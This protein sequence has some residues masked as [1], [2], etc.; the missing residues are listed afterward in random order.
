MHEVLEGVLPGAVPAVLSGPSFAADV[1]QGLPTAVTLAT[2]DQARGARLAALFA[3]ASFRPYLS[4]DIIGVELGGAVK[5]VL[6]IAAGIVAGRSLGES[7]RAALIARGLAEMTRF[8]MA[9]GAARE[10]FSGLSGLG[11]LVLTALS[12]RSRNMALGMALGQGRA[13]GELTGPG[14]ALAEGVFTAPV[15]A[16]LARE[17]NVEMPIVAAVAGVVTGAIAIDEAIV[18]LLGRPLGSE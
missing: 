2:A 15:V 16:K 12:A 1:A 18:S 4:A 11:D 7:A 3:R 8:G 9:S 13:L 17:R 5:N 6:A 10:T 14:R